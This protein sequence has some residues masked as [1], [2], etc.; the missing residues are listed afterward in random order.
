M[1]MDYEIEVDK[2][3]WQDITDPNISI[4]HTSL[5]YG[6]HRQERQETGR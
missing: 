1:T 6:L 3:L 4:R 5:P 2:N